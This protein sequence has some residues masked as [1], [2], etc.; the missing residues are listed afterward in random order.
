MVG[1]CLATHQ[2][3]R[4]PRRFFMRTPEQR[5]CHRGVELASS[6][7]SDNRLMGLPVIQ[8]IIRRRV[9][10]NFRVDAEVMAR[11]V[12]GRFQPKLLDGYAIAGICLIRLEQIRPLA[13]PAQI[14]ISSENAAHRVAVD[15][16]S[17]DGSRHTGVYIP[18]RDTNSSLVLMA[19]GRIFPGEHHKAYF[20]VQDDGRHINLR[21]ASDDGVIQ[22]R[23]D[24]CSATDLPASSRFASVADASAFFEAGSTGYSAT[25]KGGRLEGLELHTNAW[26][27]EPLKVED[28]YSSYFGDENSFPKGSVEFDCALVMRDIP[29]RWRTAPELY[30]QPS[31]A[32]VDPDSLNAHV[33][34]IDVLSD[35]GPHSDGDER[36]DIRGCWEV[37]LQDVLTWR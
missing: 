22:V 4:V 9:L 15:W 7:H 11:N 21:V 2:V 30:A 17:R 26:H 29:H 14:G 19:G 10:V 16:T 24:G 20:D 31:A 1:R 6:D 13:T 33:G 28:V 34:D 32:G 25:R 27:L 8:G 12:P 36:G 18:R 37:R 5:H 23:V 3:A 35:A